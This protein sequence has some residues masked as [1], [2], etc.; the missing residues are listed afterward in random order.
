[1]R[2]Q[3]NN[4]N[5]EPWLRT[6]GE[7]TRCYFLGLDLGLGFGPLTII[8]LILNHPMFGRAKRVESEMKYMTDHLVSLP[9]ILY[10]IWFCHVELIVTIGFVIPWWMDL[11]RR[12]LNICLGVW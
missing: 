4:S 5:S 8:G 3:V 11:I 7:V 6:Y 9:R 12:I 10:E 1:M 2:E